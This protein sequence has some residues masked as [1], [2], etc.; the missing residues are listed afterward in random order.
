[1]HNTLPLSQ[2]NIKKTS[3]EQIEEA[4]GKKRY[5]AD[6][7]PVIITGNLSSS[8]G[9]PLVLGDVLLTDDQSTIFLGYY[10]QNDDG[11]SS[12]EYKTLDNITYTP[13][14]EIKPYASAGDDKEILS[15]LKKAKSDGTDYNAGDIISEHRIIDTQN[16]TITATFYYNESQ[17]APLNSIVSTDFEL[18][19]YKL[20]TQDKSTPADLE[21]GTYTNA[22]LLAI[23]GGTKIRELVVG[24]RPSSTQPVIISKN[25]G[26]TAVY[27]G[28]TYPF[29]T[30]EHEYLS[31]FT[32][33]VPTGSYIQLYWE[34]E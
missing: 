13:S 31:D 22:D 12:V 18:L 32:I 24:V 21:E 30:K 3:L 26:N 2:L 16:N 14:G 29:K 4:S 25:G 10:Y 33:T 5:Q 11:S 23:S 27:P 28:G 9:Q 17:G 7:V 1:M 20:P 34:A 19:S 8:A 6:G 15:V